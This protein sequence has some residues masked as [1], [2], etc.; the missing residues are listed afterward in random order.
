MSEELRVVVDATTTERLL[1]AQF[2]HWADLPTAQVN[3]AG[4]DNAIY[5]L[6]EN[7]C[8][9]LPQSEWSADHVRKE[10]RWLP[11]HAERLPLEVPAPV[12]H[13]EPGE[14]YPWPWSVYQWIAGTDAV[15]ATIADPAEA[16]VALGEFVAALQGIDTTDDAPLSGSHSGDRGLPLSVRGPFVRRSLENLRGQLDTDAA[17]A[18]WESAIR[19]PAWR[20]RP[21][22][23][24][25]DLHPGNILVREGRVAA[26]IDW[27]LMSVGD[28]ALDVMAAWTVLSPSE[29]TIFREVLDVDDDTWHRARGWALCVGVIATAYYGASNPVLAGFSRRAAEESIADFLL[30]G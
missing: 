15:S 12:G 13:G 28:P 14:G 9:R 23:L 4:V 20:K 1:K 26:I 16:A 25:G 30:N 21:V 2:P 27:G 22:W 29:R 6:G 3:S 5:R 24:H 11:G 19:V 18:L 7:L 17:T 8:V 10:Q